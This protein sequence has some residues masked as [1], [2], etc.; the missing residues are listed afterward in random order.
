MERYPGQIYLY[1]MDRNP[2]IKYKPILRASENRKNILSKAEGKYFMFLD[3][4]D[5]IFILPSIKYRSR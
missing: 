2:E 3:R 1:Q 4:D 5:L